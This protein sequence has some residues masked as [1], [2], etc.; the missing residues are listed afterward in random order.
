MMLFE[1]FL[2]IFKTPFPSQQEVIEKKI[3]L[4]SAT[5]H[6]KNPSFYSQ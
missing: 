1:N 3:F 5:P 6:K 2:N 4:R